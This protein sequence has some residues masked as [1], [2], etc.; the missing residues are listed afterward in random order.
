MNATFTINE[1]SAVVLDWLSAQDVEYTP[2]DA[3]P[4]E[5]IEGFIS[6]V[7]VGAHLFHLMMSGQ[8]VVDDLD[9]D[10]E[11][12]PIFRAAEGGADPNTFG[13]KLVLVNCPS[14]A[15]AICGEMTATQVQFQREDETPDRITLTVPLTSMLKCPGGLV[16]PA[17]KEQAASLTVT[18]KH[19]VYEYCASRTYPFGGC[20]VIQIKLD[21]THMMI[22][23]TQV[24]YARIR[25]G[26]QLVGDTVIEVEPHYDAQ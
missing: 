26:E 7:E 18:V 10:I 13:F 24:L 15:D 12:N 5:T 22:D 14:V 25:N 8:I 2:L 1:V 21:V 6:P 4:G 20:D 17:V 11:N 19:T 16:T 23:L 3:K 9:C